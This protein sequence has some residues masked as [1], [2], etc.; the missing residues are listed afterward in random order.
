MALTF[1]VVSIGCLSHNRFWNEAQPVR[2]AHATT[3]LIRDGTRTILVDPSLPAEILGHR[4]GERTGLKPE[5]ID[6]VFL[7]S[8]QPV[9]RR[10]LGLFA[11]ADWL[12]F[13]AEIEAFRD[14]LTG[15]LQADP[16]AEADQTMLI[17]DELALLERI[18]AAP[19]KLTPQVHLFPSPGVTLGSCSLLLVPSTVTIAV[20]GDAIVSRDYLEHGQAY[21][22]CSDA[23]QAAE[24]LA[25][26]LDVADQV[27]CGHDNLV[28]C[29]G[30]GLGRR[31]V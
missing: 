31:M 30:S 5:Q 23:E 9:H 24:S 4:L 27:V 1:D 14:H 17:Q 28:V 18:Q 19:D 26:L 7:T 3:T 20:A 11:E 16:N 25:E 22:R 6:T 15:A 8:F 13:E 12:M 21:E 10:G 29:Q 2:T